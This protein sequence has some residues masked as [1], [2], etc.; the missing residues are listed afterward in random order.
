QRGTS[1]T[2]PAPRIFFVASAYAPVIM[3]EALVRYWSTHGKPAQFPAFP[4][5][6]VGIVRRGEDT[7]TDADG[8][9]RRLERLASR[10]VQ[11]GHQ[12]VWLDDKGR[13]TALKGVDAEFDHFESVAQGF[14]K[15][16]PGLIARA[17]ED[18]MAQFAETA[19]TLRQG[20]A[21]PRVAYVG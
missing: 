12:I 5:G 4:I 18:G 3:I 16:L 17:A 20:S 14:D 2:V 8:A 7:V 6:E 10:G 19:A 9:Q 11:G 21:A 15:A 1:R 13:L